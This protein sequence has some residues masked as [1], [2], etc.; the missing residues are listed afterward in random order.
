MKLYDIKIYPNSDAFLQNKGGASVRDLTERQKD[1]L[2][3]AL[4]LTPIFPVV[5]EVK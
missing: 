2:I 1:A 3:N 5:K 4:A